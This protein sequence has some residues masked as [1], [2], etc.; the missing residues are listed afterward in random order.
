M[1]IMSFEVLNTTIA[2]FRNDRDQLEDTFKRIGEDI[3]FSRNTDFYI[4][5][6][7]GGIKENFR[8]IPS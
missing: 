8:Y 2:E 1:L 5:Y 3:I 7:I 4:E 6:V